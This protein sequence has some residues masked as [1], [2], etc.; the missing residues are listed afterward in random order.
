MSSDTLCHAILGN[1][2]YPSRPAGGQRSASHPHPGSSLLTVS[3]PGLWAGLLSLRKPLQLSGVQSAPSQLLVPHLFQLRL[4][5]DVCGASLSVP[6]YVCVC[7][8]LMVCNCVP[9]CA[10]PHKSACVCVHFVHECACLGLVVCSVC[11]SVHGCVC[12]CLREH[13][14]ACVRVCSGRSALTQQQDLRVQCPALGRCS[15]NVR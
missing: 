11:M 5:K 4:L 1:P 3:Q 8:S 10:C 13:L 15:V 2:K 12:I 9:M 14:C 7:V 6:M